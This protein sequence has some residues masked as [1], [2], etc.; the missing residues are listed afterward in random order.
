MKTINNSRID[1]LGSAFSRAYNISMNILAG[2]E[3]SVPKECM[4][5]KHGVLISST[6]LVIAQDYTTQ[7]IRVI[8]LK[9]KEANQPEPTPTCRHG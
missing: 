8:I 1:P 3:L 2:F 5:K 6:E 9:N 4:S 7:G